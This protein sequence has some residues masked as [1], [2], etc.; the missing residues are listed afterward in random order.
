MTSFLPK[1]LIN[2]CPVKTHSEG[3]SFKNIPKLSFLIITLVVIIKVNNP[4][5]HQFRSI[6]FDYLCM[7]T[8]LIINNIFIPLLTIV[9]K[10]CPHN[11]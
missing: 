5:A 9:T 6:L 8:V 2:N 1:Y 10:T 11:P 4:S 7:K 3:C